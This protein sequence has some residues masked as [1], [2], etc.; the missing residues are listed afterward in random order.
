MGQPANPAARGRG[1]GQGRGGGRRPARRSPPRLPAVVA[2]ALLLAPLASGCTADPPRDEAE[3]GADVDSPSKQVIR[4]EGSS[5]SP[6]YSPAVRSGDALYLSGALGFDP[7][8]GELA[9]GVGAQT[10]LAM[11][12]VRTR[13]EAA[14]ADLGDLAK[15]TVLLA[16]MEDYGAMNEVYAGFF[17]D[18]EPPARSAF[19]VS[20]LAAGARVEIE[21]IAAAPR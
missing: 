9:E 12:S 19:A 5:P 8:T 7:E 6:L 4:P 11:E 1:L 15:C 14:G 21:C 16:D 17:E 13:L 2:C 3:A 18:V 20:G 10:R